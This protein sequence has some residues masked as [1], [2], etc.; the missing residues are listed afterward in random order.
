MLL[1]AVFEFSKLGVLTNFRSEGN[2]LYD[3][4][5]LLSGTAA[6]ESKTSTSIGSGDKEMPGVIVLKSHV[7]KC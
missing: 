3:L 4:K 6:P 2:L 5:T 1:I 7:S